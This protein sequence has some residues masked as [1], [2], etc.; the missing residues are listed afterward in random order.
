MHLRGAEYV[1]MLSHKEASVKIPDTSK[2][3][4][5]GTANKPARSERREA[6]RLP[7]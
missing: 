6:E 2:A 3:S 5:K 4:P 7:G 1:L